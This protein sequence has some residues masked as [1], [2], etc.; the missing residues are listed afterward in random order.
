M[1]NFVQRL[2]VGLVFVSLTSGSY[3]ALADDD[4]I[5]PQDN[6]VQDSPT[7][8]N[9][10][11]AQKKYPIMPEDD[12][13]PGSV[14][15]NPTE[16]RYP[17]KIA[18]CKRNVSTKM[19]IELIA[20]YDKKYGYK[21]QQMDRKEFKIDH[22]IPLCMGGS[23]EPD[24]LWP[25]HKSVYDITDPLEP[26]LCDLMAQGKLKQIEAIQIILDVKH[27]IYEATATVKKYGLSL[28]LSH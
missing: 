24:N 28:E 5:V 25:Q 19:K 10:H 6:P 23:N 16:Y 21:V 22:L 1:K 9:P 8:N 2:L 17:E 27:H 3:S 4:H 12:Q 14:C 13:T 18:Y 7:Q 11:G 26:A 15:E 20:L